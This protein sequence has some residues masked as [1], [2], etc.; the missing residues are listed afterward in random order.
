MAVK[1]SNSTYNS[2]SSISIFLNHILSHFEGFFLGGGV[3]IYIGYKGASDSNISG[4][5]ALWEHTRGNMSY[6]PLR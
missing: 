1:P 5:T 6:L 2:V 4:T 3:N